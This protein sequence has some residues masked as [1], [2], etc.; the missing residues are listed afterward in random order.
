MRHSCAPFQLLEKKIVFSALFLAKISALKRQI[1]QNFVLKT[2]NFSKKIHSLHPS[3]FGNLRST[4]LPKKVEC[5]PP[6]QGSNVHIHLQAFF[7][8][9]VSTVISHLIFS[10]NVTT[11][12]T[13]QFILDNDASRKQRMFDIRFK[14]SKP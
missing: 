10:T 13:Q 2:P 11:N 4:N 8:P 14:N 3:S 5:R 1:S 12:L 6:T 7:E 9:E